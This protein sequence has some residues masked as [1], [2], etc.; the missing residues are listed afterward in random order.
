MYVGY[1]NIVLEKKMSI[2]P[3]LTFNWIIDFFDVEFC[4]FYTYFGC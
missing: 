3:L 2:G 4:E 1:V